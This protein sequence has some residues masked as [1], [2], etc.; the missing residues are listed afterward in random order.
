MVQTV[1]A[2]LELDGS[3]RLLEPVRTTTP[4]RALVM[5][6]QESPEALPSETAILSESALADWN[7]TEEDVAWAH[8]PSAKSS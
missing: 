3:V 4:R 2:I 6:L 5:I 1:E 8:L 7:R